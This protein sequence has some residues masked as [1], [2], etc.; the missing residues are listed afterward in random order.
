MAVHISHLGHFDLAIHPHVP[1]TKKTL[2]FQRQ[3]VLSF[4][5]DPSSRLALASASN[6][7]YLWSREVLGLLPLYSIAGLEFSSS[8]RHGPFLLCSNADPNSVLP[9]ILAGF[10]GGLVAVVAM[11]DIDDFAG[12]VGA[13]AKNHLFFL[14]SD[15]AAGASVGP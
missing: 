2:S 10:E 15:S 1:R 3:P 6:H 12:A 5:W 9:T 13:A 4:S 11:L 14:F 7:V 8:S